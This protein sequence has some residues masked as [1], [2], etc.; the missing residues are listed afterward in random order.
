MR[1]GFGKDD[2]GFYVNASALFVMRSDGTAVRQLMSTRLRDC[3]TIYGNPSWSPDGSTIAL[4]VVTWDGDCETRPDGMKLV[5]PSSGS[6][7]QFDVPGRQVVWSRDGAWLAYTNGA[8]V[9]ILAPDG[10]RNTVIVG[11][12]L[13]VTYA[14]PRWS[15]DG[16]RVAFIE[17]REG[18]FETG[19][20]STWDVYVVNADG[21][22]K[23]RLSRTPG[24]EG[25]LD[26]S[27]AGA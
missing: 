21:S 18:D 19:R 14:D 5:D 13:G 24:V 11:D 1:Y 17:E 4:A 2:E 7:R 6:A 12:R 20:R 16:G 25:S 9:G 26:W 10:T 22:G 3:G 15:P 27:A 8:R 23:K